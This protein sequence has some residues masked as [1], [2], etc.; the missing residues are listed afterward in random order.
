VE[1]PGAYFSEKLS[2]KAFH[3]LK[4]SQLC[5]SLSKIKNYAQKSLFS[6]AC[7]KWL[8][9]TGGKICGFKLNN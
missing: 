8:N 3:S 1:N 6:L 4:I 2:F 5:I 9:S 7:N